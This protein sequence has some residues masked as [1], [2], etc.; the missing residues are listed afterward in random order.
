M[1]EG[2]KIA[3]RLIDFAVIINECEEL[4]AITAKSIITAK[5]KKQ[6]QNAKC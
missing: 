1:N 5:S 2:D 6:S 3:G 4:C